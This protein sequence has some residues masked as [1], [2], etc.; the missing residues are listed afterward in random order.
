M[1][2]GWTINT[3]RSQ[4]N[5]SKQGETQRQAA[6]PHRALHASQNVNNA[7]TLHT[8]DLSLKKFGLRLFL[9]P[10][11]CLLPGL[12]LADLQAFSAQ[13]RVQYLKMHAANVSLELE[14]N[15]EGWL[16]QRSSRAASGLAT[17]LAGD[18][19]KLDEQ[20]WF[21]LKNNTP[22]PSKYIQKKPGAKR[23][24]RHIE[25]Q[26]AEKTALIS[27]DRG[28][29]TR[30]EIG[31][32]VQDQV[33]AVLAVM[34]QMQEHRDNFELPVLDRRGKDVAKFEV[35]GT[36]DLVVSKKKYKTLH[37]AQKTKK[38]ITNYWLALEHHMVPVKIS[39]EEVGEEPAIMLLK[40]LTT[41]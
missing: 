17:W 39:H 16:M 34:L 21:E 4:C 32:Q 28:K 22:R 31:E 27:N 2:H 10:L 15:G 11:I 24:R 1:K 12:A 25:I 20:S 8:F 23:G 26:F 40:T 9:V 41:P 29:K 36:E 5:T 13:Y 37:I 18:K 7:M 19:L 33:S 30:V 38:R 14:K 6:V 35:L 3:W